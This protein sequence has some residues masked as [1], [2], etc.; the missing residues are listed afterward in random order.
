[1]LKP[2]WGTVHGNCGAAGRSSPGGGAN[3]PGGVT[4]CPRASFLTSSV[5]ISSA[6]S[7]DD[8]S[9][10]DS[11]RLLE[12]IAT[13]SVESLLTSV[14]H[15]LLSATLRR[16]N[17]VEDLVLLG[18]I[19]ELSRSSLVVDREVVVCV[20]WLRRSHF[21]RLARNW[22]APKT[23]AIIK[24]G[25]SRERISD[26]SACFLEAPMM[27][28]VEGADCSIKV[29]TWKVEVTIVVRQG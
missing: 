1:M 25:K 2:V 3:G 24:A 8:V 10:S 23:V 20:G 15:S 21:A 27:E 16:L 4:S 19:S 18:H 26:V 14:D 29:L 6:T 5:G 13:S 11:W 7:T 17:A 22:N 9:V 12:P 28:L